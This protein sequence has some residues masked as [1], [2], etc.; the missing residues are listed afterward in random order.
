MFFPD[1]Q[2][3]LGYVDS[4]VLFILLLTV[5]TNTEK[6]TAGAIYPEMSIFIISSCAP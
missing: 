4:K 6:P 1:K 2:K 3:Y 5:F